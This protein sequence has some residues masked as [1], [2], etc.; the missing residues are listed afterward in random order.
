MTP[1]QIWA[2]VGSAAALAAVAVGLYVAGS[3]SEER[4]LRLDERR[5][6]DLQRLASAIDAYRNENG[7]LPPG[8]EQL[9]TGR[10]LP[11]VPVDP[12]SG[13]PYTYEILGEDE[14]RLCADFE[15]A[16][17]PAEPRG[18]WTHAAGTQCFDVDRAGRE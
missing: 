13:A 10:R 5:V 7:A 1:N 8:F 2:A 4:A 15:R 3:P 11:D 14:Y 16:S 9:M 12:V 18:F 6:A 17:R